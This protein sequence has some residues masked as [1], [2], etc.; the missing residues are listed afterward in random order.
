MRMQSQSSEE[1]HYFIRDTIVTDV[2]LPKTMDKQQQKEHDKQMMG[3][4][5]YLIRYPPINQI[6]ITHYYM[7]SLTCVCFVS[8]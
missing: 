3:V 6:K 5:K 8:A 2:N 4:P 7:A 1:H